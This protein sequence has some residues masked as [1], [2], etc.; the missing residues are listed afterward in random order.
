MDGGWI[1][2]SGWGLVDRGKGVRVMDRI[3]EGEKEE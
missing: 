3:E 2:W 1:E